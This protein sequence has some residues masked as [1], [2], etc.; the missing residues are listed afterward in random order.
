MLLFQSKITVSLSK[1]IDIL[2][3]RVYIIYINIHIFM[4]F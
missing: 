3:E 4:Y 1:K 2:N